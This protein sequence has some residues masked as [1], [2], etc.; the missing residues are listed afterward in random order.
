MISAEKYR[1]M[2]PTK[3]A[4]TSMTSAQYQE[5]YGKGAGKKKSKYGNIKVERHGIKFDSV[6][7]ADRYEVLKVLEFSGEISELKLQQAFPLIVIGGKVKTRYRADY[8]YM[9][10]GVLIVEDVKSSMTRKL[11][12]YILKRKLMLS[13]H[14]ITITET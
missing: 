6:K 8:T 14:G 2:F 12:L 3:Q 13:V 9:R 7:E 1:K 11:P 10:D 5:A 4:P